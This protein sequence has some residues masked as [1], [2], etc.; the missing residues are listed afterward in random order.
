MN[1]EKVV[2]MSYPEW[3]F[4]FTNG[5]P[6]EEQKKYYE[7]YL[8][9]ESGRIFF[10]AA[11]AQLDP[12]HAL[13][14]N[15]KNNDRAPLLLVAGELDHVVPAHVVRSNYKHYEHST[16]RTNFKEF[17]GRAHLLLS[18]EGWEEIADFAADWLEEISAAGAGASVRA[19]AQA[20][21]LP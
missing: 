14:V 12:H 1:W 3:Q 15:F 11:F 21:T 13:R 10:Q 20:N 2:H 5:F 17:P 4:A 9:P 16:A 19:A 8:V 7:R 18:Q 6:E